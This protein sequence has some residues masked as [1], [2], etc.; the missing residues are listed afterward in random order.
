MLNDVK[1][2]IDMGIEFVKTNNLLV[3]NILFILGLIIAL[4]CCF[5]GYVKD[6]A[7]LTRMGGA[8]IFF[9]TLV[10]L[11]IGDL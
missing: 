2:Y 1:Y 8:L 6:N 7:K 3:V 10:R 5:R 11:M 9:I 4:I